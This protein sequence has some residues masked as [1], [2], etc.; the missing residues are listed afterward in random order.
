MVDMTCT[1]MLMLL[2]SESSWTLLNTLVYRLTGWTDIL[3]MRIPAMNPY[4][5]YSFSTSPP[6]NIV[7]T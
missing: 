2:L 1:Y 5:I 7:G 4:F 3:I 6:S